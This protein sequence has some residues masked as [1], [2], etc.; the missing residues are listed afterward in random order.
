MRYLLDQGLARSA[1]E[2]LRH[3]GIESVHV[4]DLG[5]AAAS[6]A[7]I[8]EE[9]LRRNAIVVT[10]DADFHS[11][12][13]LSNATMPSVIRIRVEGLKGI[14]VSKMIQRVAELAREDL[15]AGAAVTVTD[16]RIAIKRLPLIPAKDKDNKST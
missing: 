3:A 7:M 16:R 14:D 6:D 1:V 5:M 4:G 11:L 10:L 2:H 15:E 13:A 8:L 9:G 12:L